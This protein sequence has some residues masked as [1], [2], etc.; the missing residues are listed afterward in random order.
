[1]PDQKPPRADG[2]ERETLLALQ[3]YQRESLQPKIA[4]VSS[5]G[6]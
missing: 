4:G 3:R 1:M 6:R 5:T 2:S